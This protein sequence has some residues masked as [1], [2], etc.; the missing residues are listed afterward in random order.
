MPGATNDRS[1]I[2][3]A[4]AGCD[5]VPTALVPRGMQQYSTGT[6]QAVLDFAEGPWIS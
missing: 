5:A 6:A 1:V 4:V 2:Q 3:G